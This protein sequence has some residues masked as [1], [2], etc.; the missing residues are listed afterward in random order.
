[1]RI[2]DDVN[3]G[4]N[5]QPFLRKLSTQL[6]LTSAF[7]RVEH[8]SLLKIMDEIGVPSF[9]GLFYCGFLNDH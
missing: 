5:Q 2:I 7:N 6:D 4:F 8:I 3:N 1:M 9:L